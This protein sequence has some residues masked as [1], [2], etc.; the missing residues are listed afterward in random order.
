MQVK[1]ALQ[2]ADLA[3]GVVE[4]GGA[5]DAAAPGR[6]GAVPAAFPWEMSAPGPVPSITQQG[7][8]HC[9][10]LTALKRL[11]WGGWGASAQSPDEPELVARMAVGPRGLQVL[12]LAPARDRHVRARTAQVVS[13][14]LP[15]CCL[16]SD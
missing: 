7:L 8:A 15:L 16:T 1:P 3:A 4:V 14:A 13:D 5:R 12:K 10:R 11:E 9:S 2:L 6:A